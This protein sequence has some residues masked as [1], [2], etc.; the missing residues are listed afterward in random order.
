MRLRALTA[1]IYMHTRTFH[2]SFTVACAFD[3]LYV[4]FS[5]RLDL[6]LCSTHLWTLWET[7][8]RRHGQQ[9]QMKGFIFFFFFL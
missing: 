8:L 1:D 3:G 9:T 5:P 4:L 2:G 6:W 7:H